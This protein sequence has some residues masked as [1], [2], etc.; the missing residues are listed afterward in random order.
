MSVNQAGYQVP[1]FQI[2]DNALLI[3]LSFTA[4]LNS[5]LSPV[6]DYLGVFNNLAGDNV[7]QTGVFYQK[8]S[9][10]IKSRHILFGYRASL[11]AGQGKGSRQRN[12]IFYKIPAP[13]MMKQFVVHISLRHSN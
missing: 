1:A 4:A 6:N 9:C 10:I 11:N 2:K 7:H 8:R 5:Y 12:G 13:E 3:F